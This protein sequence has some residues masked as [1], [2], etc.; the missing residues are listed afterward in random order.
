MDNNF[1]KLVRRL[2]LWVAILAILNITIVS[3]IA[4]NS[5]RAKKHEAAVRSGSSSNNEFF[6]NY[7]ELSD[8]QKV[9]FYSLF[10]NYNHERKEVGLRLRDVKERLHRPGS[11]ND[12]VVMNKIYEDFIA[13]QALNRDLT[14]KLYDS[15]RAICSPIQV[16]KFNNIIS[17][18]IIS[19]NHHEN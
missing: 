13:A 5:Y 18:T 17:Q 2:K 8:S 9:Q 4:V 15:I 11:N 16:K 7:L 12:S 14:L 19:D 1:L 3:T 10:D 6:V